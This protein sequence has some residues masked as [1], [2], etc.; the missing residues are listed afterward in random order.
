MRR[1]FA[2]NL[3]LLLAINALIKPLY[4]F[5]VDLGVQNAVGTVEYGRY[6]SWYAFAFLF[7]V[8]YDLGLINY[9]SVTLSKRPGLLT[10]RLPVMLSL[11]LGL[12]LVYLAVV[13]GV[14]Y[15]YGA[16]GRDLQLV[17]LAG[18]YHA[19]IS[20]LHLMRTT[21]GAQA[22]YRFNSLVSVV[23]RALLIVVI[24][25]LLLFPGLYA[26]TITV[27][28]FFLAQIASVWVATAVA[29]WGTDLSPG[30]RWLAWRPAEALSL[31]RAAVPYAL[32]LLLTT[33][34]TRIDVVM[35]EALSPR[36]YYE[37][38]KYAAAYRLLDAINMVGFMFAS[39]LV[40]M[41]SKQVT[42]GERVT[43][44][45]RQAAGY[46]TAIGVGLAAWT[47]FHAED[48]MT[49][50]YTE[51]TPDWGAVLGVLMW[52][53]VGVGFTYVFGSYLLTRERFGLLN[54]AFGVALVANVGLNYWLV[55]HYGA[56]GAALATIVTQGGIAGFEYV[57][58]AV[59]E[60]R[61]HGRTV[62][63][64]LRG[65][66]PAVRIAAYATLVLGSGYLLSPDLLSGSTTIAVLAQAACC[67]LAGVLTG[68]FGS[69]AEVRALLS[70]K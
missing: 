58:S 18:V 5:G 17:G 60:A 39:L 30:Q 26:G 7:G 66:L 70:G 1:E 6:A 61:L 48:L 59:G 35:V 11:K 38:G 40:P 54:T 29:V 28:F 41:L 24:G 53:S 47:T 51:A 19:A 23:D 13:V 32:V 10:E 25:G 69:L 3:A 12:S 49:G 62:A 56:T 27:E 45:L 46:L 31:A 33:A 57:A 8:V 50:L 64:E 9:N 65:G 43:P 22:K 55:P 67:A 36:G 14:A 15:A 2:V 68:L 63:A 21:L 16:R 52:A 44:L 20:L 4:L 37:A 42:A 34:F